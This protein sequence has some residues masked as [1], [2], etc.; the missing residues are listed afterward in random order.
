MRLDNELQ[1]GTDLKK[2][3]C[4]LA[5]KQTWTPAAA[6]TLLCSNF[7][8]EKAK[9]KERVDRRSLSQVCQQKQARLTA[10]Q[11]PL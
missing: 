3:I 10:G 7:C 1:L 6:S 11:S 4:V 5:P 2:M 8:V 9:K